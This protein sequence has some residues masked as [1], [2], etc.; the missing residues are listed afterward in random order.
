MRRLGEDGAYV[1]IR[2]AGKDELVLAKESDQGITGQKENEGRTMQDTGGKA[3]R[4]SG[5]RRTRRHASCSSSC[6]TNS[7]HES[8]A[9]F[10]W[11]SSTDKLKEGGTYVV[12]REKV[13]C[14]ADGGESRPPNYP[15]RGCA[16][17]RHPQHI[18]S[19]RP[20]PCRSAEP[21]RRPRESSS[22][23]STWL[24]RRTPLDAPT[25]IY[26]GRMSA[27]PGVGSSAC[28]L[29]VWIVLDVEVMCGTCGSGTGRYKDIRGRCVFSAAL[30]FDVPS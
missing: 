12:R 7:L 16:R 21:M 14:P 11:Q 5:A 9:R 29:G 18:F 17:L 2:A 10:A 20:S 13:E 23:P 3:S 8:A 6:R 27:G 22:R 28:A 24:P 15:P 19:R 1:A 25:R 30:R 26:A 4:E